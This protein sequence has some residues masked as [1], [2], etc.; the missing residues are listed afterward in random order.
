MDRTT[1][2]RH[3]SPGDPFDDPC[4]GSTLRPATLAFLST[5]Y[6][7]WLCFLASRGWLDP[8]Q[9]PLQRI[10]RGRLRAYFRA[11]RAADYADHT[12]ISRFSSLTYA[13][14]ILAPEQDVSWIQRPDGITIYALLSKTQRSMLVP[15][16]GVLFQWAVDMMDTAASA[17]AYQDG[18]LLALFASR[19]RRLRS[20]AL[21]RVGQELI[22]RGE[23][24]RIELTPEQVKTGKPDRFDLPTALT[25][26]IRHHLTV[27][28]PEL[29]AGRSHDALWI[30][31]RG[32]AWA[33]QGI[34]HRVRVLTRCHFGQSFGPHRFRHAIAT[35]ATLRDPAYP[36]LAA[37]LLGISGPV[38][39]EHYNRAGQSQA[40]LM[41]DKAI[42]RR[43]D[44]L[45]RAA[46]QTNRSTGMDSGRW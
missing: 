18:L 42:A 45:R 7:C 33:V 13:M 17:R 37:G 16:S 12:I 31:H 29:L 20:M 38:I 15:D 3:C 44:K 21:L 35:T 25:P 1:W 5:G 24:Y 6:G 2:V 40:A 43:R 23:H 10:T 22:L 39:E 8:L 4:Y 26:Y 11:L 9:P 30:G 27:V 46:A 19:G 36:G 28:R 32:E 14:K 41:F 34:K